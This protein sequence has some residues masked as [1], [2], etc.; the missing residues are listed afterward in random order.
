MK[1]DEHRPLAPQLEAISSEPDDISDVIDGLRELA[2]RTDRLYNGLM[3]LARRLTLVDAHLE[4][5]GLPP[6]YINTDKPGLD[7]GHEAP[8]PERQGE[9]PQGDPPG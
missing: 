8:H 5:A 7:S 6:S 1:F 2:R 4:A 3:N 9:P